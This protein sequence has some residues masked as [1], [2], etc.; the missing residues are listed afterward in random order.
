MILLPL[1]YDMLSSFH[2]ILQLRLYQK[3][4][5]LRLRKIDCLLLMYQCTQYKIHFLLNKVSFQFK[6]L[7]LRELFAVQNILEMFFFS[8]FS[9]C[10]ETDVFVSVVSK[11]IRNTETNQNKPT[12]FVISFAK[13]TEN[14]PKQIEFRFVS[15][16]TENIFCLFRGHPNLNICTL[17]AIP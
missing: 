10:F 9:V 14:Q 7:L 2:I 13:Q 6:A 4:M 17:A 12:N 15:V 16:R 5:G 1:H 3:I 8:F 11:R